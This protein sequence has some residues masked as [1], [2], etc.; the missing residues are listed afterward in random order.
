MNAR[1]PHLFSPLT[2]R[3]VTIRNRIL[4]SGHGTRMAKG[5][6]DDAL[7]AYH[8][9]RAA[10]GA[11][12]I[13][14][15]VAIVHT[16]AYYTENCLNAATDACIPGY[17]RLAEAVHGHGCKLFGQLFHPGRQVVGSADGSAAGARAGR[18]C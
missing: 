15:E 3:G 14:T 17:R 6:P 16:S 4:F 18:D 1:L 11:G 10:G 8:T 7:I 9:A 13:V 5:A 12:L 2:L